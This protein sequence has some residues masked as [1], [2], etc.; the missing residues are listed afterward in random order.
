MVLSKGHEVVGPGYSW[1]SG[2]TTR[3]TDRGRESN[4]SNW[5]GW[6]R[7]EYDTDQQT[8]LV[9]QGS[10]GNQDGGSGQ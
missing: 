1:L 4:N 8:Y 6:V 10:W 7:R 5:V 9:T 3:V 2:Y